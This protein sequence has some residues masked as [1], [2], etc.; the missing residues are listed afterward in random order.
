MNKKHRRLKALV[1][2]LGILIVIFFGLIVTTIIFRLTKM[3]ARNE[4]PVAA[5]VDSADTAAFGD[6]RVT[7]PED[8]QV[9]QILVEGNRLLVRLDSAAG[10]PGQV[11][12]FDLATGVRLGTLRFEPESLSPEQ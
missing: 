6:L 12:I 2:G 7:V 11:M 3:P 8:L 1:I 9:T 5:A 10:A 4:P